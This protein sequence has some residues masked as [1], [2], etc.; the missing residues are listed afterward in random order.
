MELLLVILAAM[1]GLVLLASL[2]WPLVM[3]Y[4]L[5][6][7]KL[8]R[9]DSIRGQPR[10][11][12]VDALLDTVQV[13]TLASLK[14]V[15][16]KDLAVYP[17]VRLASLLKLSQG[18]EEANPQTAAYIRQQAVDFVVCDNSTQ[19]P[20]LV[21]MLRNSLDQSTQTQHRRQQLEEV[22][23]DAGLPLLPI[24]RQQP[25]TSVQMAQSLQSA[26]T[27]FVKQQADAA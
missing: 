22:L 10:Y 25:P 1:S 7:L 26:L 5:F 2:A 14:Q 12:K 8:K 27:T 19:K 3:N 6:K 23:T 17:K 15:V 20:V 18:K 13:Q 11:R 21:V 4:R 9:M 16:G 24:A